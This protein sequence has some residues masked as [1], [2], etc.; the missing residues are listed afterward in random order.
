[1]QVQNHDNIFCNIFMKVFS[2]QRGDASAGSP[3]A[4]ERPGGRTVAAVLV[5]IVVSIPACHA[6]DRGSIPRRGGHTPFLVAAVALCPAAR[7][8]RALGLVPPPLGEA[9]GRGALPSHRRP[10]SPRAALQPEP[11]VVAGRTVAMAELA[12]PWRPQ[13]C[14]TRAEVGARPRTHPHWLPQWAPRLETP[15]P[16]GS[17]QRRDAC[18]QLGPVSL[19]RRWKWPRSAPGG[20]GLFW[21]AGCGK[22]RAPRCPPGLRAEACACRGGDRRA[23][24]AKPWKRRPGAGGPVDPGSCVAL[25]RKWRRTADGGDGDGTEPPGD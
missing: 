23:R 12:S 22:L 3:R 19:S 4:G 25:A 1:M 24:A 14:P 11:F 2:I 5:S 10:P 13:P 17:A 18:R 8:P 21:P 16:C 20:E 6:G 15:P 7:P 9:P